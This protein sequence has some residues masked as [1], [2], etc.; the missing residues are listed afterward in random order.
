MAKTYAMLYG[1]I[2]YSTN[3]R[4]YNNAIKKMIRFFNEIDPLCTPERE[5]LLASGKLAYNVAQKI[6]TDTEDGGVIVCEL[7]QTRLYILSKIIF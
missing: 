7:L 3:Y 6:K 2:G 5:G 4:S 1:Y